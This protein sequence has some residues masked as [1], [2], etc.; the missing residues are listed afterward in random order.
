MS[1][2]Y[3][4]K[5]VIDLIYSL[6]KTIYSSLMCALI[7]FLL[8]L[9]SLSQSNIKVIK[10]EK[11]QMVAREKTK[12]Y[13]KCLKIKICI[14]YIILF[15]LSF[16]FWYYIAAFCVVYKNTQKH[17]FLDTLVSFCFSMFTPFLFCLITASFRIWGLSAKSKCLYG[18]NKLLQVIL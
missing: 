13:M 16:L 18:T 11:D 7:T 14:F 9:L 6:P 10:E 17:L 3:R 8:N 5:G 12:K 1:Y 2:N 15:G 4:N